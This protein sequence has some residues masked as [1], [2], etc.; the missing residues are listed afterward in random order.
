MDAILKQT[1]RIDQEFAELGTTVERSWQA[2]GNQLLVALGNLNEYL[3]LT[4]KLS[5]ALS[6]I[7]RFTE[8]LAN[9]RAELEGRL[10]G[11]LEREKEYLDVLNNDSIINKA[12][13]KFKDYE[14]A[15]EETRFQIDLVRD[16]LAQGHA[17][18]CHASNPR[19][20]TRAE[21]GH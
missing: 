8:N 11:L 12:R 17:G 19:L 4:E 3:G 5:R 16:A 15:L 13:R 7:I 20:N 6:A 14:T 1:D 2:I 21:H 10:K 9:K 18:R